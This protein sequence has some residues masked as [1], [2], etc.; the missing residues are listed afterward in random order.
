M[1]SMGIKG[2]VRGTIR[3]A[4]LV[5]ALTSLAVL[6]VASQ[7]FALVPTGEYVT[8]SDCPT[9]NAEVTSCLFA[10]T[11]GGEFKIGS[12]EVPL[13]KTITLQ[14]GLV[15]VTENN[16]RLIGTRDGNTLSKTPETVPGGLLKILAPSFF[17][18]P[19]KKLFNEFI[20]KGITG[21]AASTELEGEP[22]LFPLNVLFGSGTALSLPVRV[23]LENGFLGSKCYVGSKASPVNL[24]L[25]TGT[26][27]PPLPN[28]PITGN[29]GELSTRGEGNI[30]VISKNSLVNNSF[31]APEAEGC[32]SQIL[33]GLFTGLI[34]GAVDSQIGLP[35]AAGNNTA[36]LNGSQEIASA[37]AVKASEK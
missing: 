34:D 16:L 17:P 23:H 2:S 6:G 22:H 20:N 1:I 21:V 32:G 30:L 35:S 10:Q 27:S 4:L 5:A 24:E 18:E 33:F 8:F 7:S 9:A 26:T 31:A 11:S 12:T 14:G 37:E 29:P 13:T 19:L 25:T 15:Q 28:K 36:I 3:S